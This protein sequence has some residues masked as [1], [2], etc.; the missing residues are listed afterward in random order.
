MSCPVSLLRLAPV[1]LLGVAA[2]AAPR[3]NV[4]V[5]PSDDMGY[6]D[7]G[8]YGGEIA[9]PNLD[10]LAAEGLRFTQFY[11]TGRCCPTRASLLNGLH[12]HQTDVGHMMEDHGHEGYRGDLNRRCVTLAEALRPTGGKPGPDAR[13]SSPGR[14]SEP[15]PRRREQGAQNG[16][17]GPIQR[18]LLVL[19]R[20]EQ[21]QEQ[22]QVKESNRRFSVSP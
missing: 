6:S 2:A 15:R 11:N 4:V 9:T 21:E 1:L 7:V 20:G 3:P 18:V 22:E 17:P 10:A 5:I 14:R 12:P 13:M 19:H 16:T 8:C